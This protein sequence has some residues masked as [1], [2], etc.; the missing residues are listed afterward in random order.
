MGTQAAT[1]VIAAQYGSV[2]DIEIVWTLI[3]LVG[4]SFAFFNLIEAI[5][6]LEALKAIGDADG[7]RMIAWLTIRLETTRVVI[8]SIF[9]LIGI[10]AMTIVDPP[11]QR[12]LPTKIIVVNALFRWGL[13]VSALLI[14]YQSYA[15][16]QMRRVIRR[17]ALVFNPRQRMLGDDERGG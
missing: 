9:I 1:D 13:V 4:V 10:L 11:D 16:F 6:D 3:A 7:R 17:S 5:R 8:Q 2:S 15:N 12:A 14:C